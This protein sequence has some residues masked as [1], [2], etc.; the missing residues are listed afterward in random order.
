[1][2]GVAK[3]GPKQTAEAEPGA[4]TPESEKDA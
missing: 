2:V 1:M 4:P 3:G